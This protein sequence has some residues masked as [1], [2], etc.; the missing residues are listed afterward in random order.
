MRKCTTLE[1]EIQQ[2]TI[3]SLTTNEYDVGRLEHDKIIQLVHDE[4]QKSPSLTAIEFFGK[5]IGLVETEDFLTN[6]AS[7]LE[8]VELS[9]QVFE[10]GERVRKIS[11]IRNLVNGDIIVHV[12]FCYEIE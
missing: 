9:I 2:G 4:F 8:D 6:L 7:S 11:E 1:F 3:T 10:S 12:E 5:V